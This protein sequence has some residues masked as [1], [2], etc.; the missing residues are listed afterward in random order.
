MPAETP[1]ERLRAGLEQMDCALLPAQVGALLDYLELLRQWN[2]TYNLTA[3]TDPAE[4][5]VRHLLDSLSVRPF[6]GAGRLLDAGTGAGLPGVPLAIACPDLAVTL[7][8]ANG[9]KFR[10]LRHVRRT[11]GLGNVTPVQ[12]RLEQFVAPVPFDTII[13]R[14]FSSLS[15]FVQ[16]SRGLASPATR[17]C[18]MK[19]RYPAA[20]IEAL[21]GDVRLL[22]VEQLT[23]PGLQEDRH[24]VIMCVNA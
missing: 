23:V 12:A 1:A 22:S 9:K 16:A 14:A 20:E 21:P 11:L 24:L 3:V 8:D 19:G 18:A 5:V 6:I 2:R 4:M 15:G 10:F 7:L 13:S 17:I